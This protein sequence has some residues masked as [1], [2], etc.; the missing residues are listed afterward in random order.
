MEGEP[1][2]WQEIGRAYRNE[3]P[4]LVSSLVDMLPIAGTVK[5][6]DEVFTGRDRISGENVS[7]TVGIISATASFVPGGKKAAKGMAKMLGG[8]LGKGSAKNLKMEAEV[9]METSKSAMK[10]GVESEKKI[11]KRIGEEKNTK[12]F[13]TSNGNVIPDVVSG[14]ALHEIKDVKE[15]SNVRQLRREKEVAKKQGVN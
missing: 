8:T 3:A 12:K 7:Q 11:L 2:L 15:I 6:I 4:N 10:R 1:S 9:L 5:S 13:A 14:D